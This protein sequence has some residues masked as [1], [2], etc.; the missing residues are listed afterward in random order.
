M[1]RLGPFVV[2][3]AWVSIGHGGF[4]AFPGHPQAE[5]PQLTGSL[6]G[7]ERKSYEPR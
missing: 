3:L 6:L 1:K 4:V 7:V 5:V 2:A